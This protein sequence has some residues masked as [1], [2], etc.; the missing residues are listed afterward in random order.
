[1][2]RNFQRVSPAP[3]IY[4]HLIQ[5]ARAGGAI[6]PVPF[7]APALDLLAALARWKVESSM[8]PAPPASV[9]R[10]HVVEVGAMD[11]T[12]HRVFRDPHCPDCSAT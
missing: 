8:Q 1:L 3:E 7:P 2:I 10:L 12:T 4:G 11:C 6:P 9:Y 5:H